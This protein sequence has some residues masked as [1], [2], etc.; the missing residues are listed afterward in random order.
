M[1]RRREACGRH[2]GLK[3]DMIGR[4]SAVVRDFA[5]YG[6]TT[7]ET[8]EFGLLVRMAGRRS[9]G[10]ERPWSTATRPSSKPHG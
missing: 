5:R 2:A 8:D 10:G 1:A 7:G 4:G 9:T 3:E 6:E